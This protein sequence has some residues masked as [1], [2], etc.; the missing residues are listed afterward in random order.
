MRLQHGPCSIEYPKYPCQ[1][2]GVPWSSLFEN[3]FLLWGTI[4]F[5]KFKQLPAAVISLH[6]HVFDQVNHTFIQHVLL[7]NGC[8][9]WWMPAFTLILPGSVWPL[10]ERQIKWLSNAIFTFHYVAWVRGTSISLLQARD[11]RWKASLLLQIGVS[12]Q[13]IGNMVENLG[14][15]MSIRWRCTLWNP[16]HRNLYHVG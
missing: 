5:A 12:E 15:L 1:A 2:C 11:W 6:H 4:D 9:S 8:L 10:R 14:E 13:G 7:N 16:M 3:L